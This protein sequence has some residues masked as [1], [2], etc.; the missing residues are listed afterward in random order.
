[1]G[2][3]AMRRTGAVGPVRD[4]LR[5]LVARLVDRIPGTCGYTTWR[6]ANRR[7]RWPIARAASRDCR[8]LAVRHGWCPCARITSQGGDPS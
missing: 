2:A 8:A 7:A 6:W 3:R 1:V 4:R 5:H